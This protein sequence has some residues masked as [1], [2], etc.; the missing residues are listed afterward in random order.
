[1]INHSYLSNMNIE[2]F[3]DYCLSL[4]GVDEGTPFGP[5]V[6]V[7][8][9]MGKIFAITGL[10]DPEF[11]VNLKCDPDRA[12][13]LRAQYPDIIPGWHMNKEHWNTVYFERGMIEEDLLIE[14]IDHSY[15]LIGQSLK[16]KDRDRLAEL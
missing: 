3:R 11:R 5:D 14:L 12:I 7:F 9:V 8:R 1:M 16:K 13:E 15:E 2:A 4:K 10:T 6:L